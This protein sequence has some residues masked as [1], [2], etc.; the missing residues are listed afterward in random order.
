MKVELNGPL[1]V[2][3]RVWLERARVKGVVTEA[4]PDPSLDVGWRKVAV[5]VVESPRGGVQPGEVLTGCR[6]DEWVR[7]GHINERPCACGCG[8][9][10][11]RFVVEETY[12]GTSKREN[13]AQYASRA[14]RQRAYRAR[15]KAG[16]VKP[17]P[18]ERQKA[19]ERLE[20]RLAAL[21]RERATL[22]A[23]MER[24]AV[25]AGGQEELRWLT[26]GGA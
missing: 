17:R 10:V 22:R 20:I 23:E 15:K 12:W 3:E 11:P 5:R 14:C 8:K 25:V 1:Q 7:V 18:T 4:D 24:L 9:P 21:Q 13:A 26:R 19:Q 16:M 2:G 6:E